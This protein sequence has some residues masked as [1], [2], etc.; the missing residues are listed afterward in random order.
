LSAR[1]RNQAP[2][3]SPRNNGRAMSTPESNWSERS[4]RNNGHV[5]STSES[6]WSEKSPRNNGH[7]M[8]TPDSNWSE[9]SSR[10]L[11]QAQF[12]VYGSGKSGSSDH[13]S[14]SPGRKVYSNANGSTYPSERV[15]EFGSVGHQPVEGSLQERSWQQSS[16]SALAQNSSGSLPPPGMQSP[17][18]LLGI[19]QDRYGNIIIRV[20]FYLD[21]VEIFG[22]PF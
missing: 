13:T 4:P 11:A 19:N 16:G 2:V 8:S 12:P 14:G 6:N 5:M 7:V 17:K 1:G 10:E 20:N 22:T 9:R 15:V 3:R 21:L 18:P